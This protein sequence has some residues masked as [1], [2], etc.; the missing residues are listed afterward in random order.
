MTQS[1]VVRNSSSVRCLE[2]KPITMTTPVGEESGARTGVLAS[3]G[4]RL[5]SSGMRSVINCRAVRRSVSSWKITVTTERPWIDCER[6]I[7]TPGVL[8][9]TV[10]TGR[11]TSCSTSSGTKPGASV[12]T[13][14]CGGTNEGKT[15]TSLLVNSCTPR[16]VSNTIKAATRR[17]CWIQNPMIAFSTLFAA[18]LQYLQ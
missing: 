4:K 6:T 14:T 15:S 7:S 11:V 5:L 2:V 3:T 13:T 10:S 18:L 17:G 8:C 1:A 9:S 16:M 12:C